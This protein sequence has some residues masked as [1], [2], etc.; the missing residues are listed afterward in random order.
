[1]R[2]FQSLAG[3]VQD[4]VV[5]I[6]TW[7]QLYSFY[8]QK[9]NRL[10]RNDQTPQYP[11]SVLCQG[12]TGIDVLTIQVYL[13]VIS[14][15]YT[16][17]PP[18][19][20]TALYNIQTVIAVRAFQRQFDLAATGRVDETTWN[21]ICLEYRDTLETENFECRFLDV[22]YPGMP[23]T[24]DQTNIFVRIALYY[25]NMIAAFD[26]LLEP[27]PITETFTREARWAIEEFQRTRGLP[28]TGAVDE[29]TWS[30]LYAQYAAAFRDLNPECFTD[31]ELPVPFSTLRVG[32]SGVYV[33]QLQIW[34]N[35]LSAY[36][37]DL[38]P[39]PVNGIYNEVTESNV[40][41]LQEFLDLPL[42]G[43][44]DRAT[45]KMIRSAYHSAIEDGA[46][47]DEAEGDTLDVTY[48]SRIVSMTD[49]VSC[50]TRVRS[51]AC[52]ENMNGT[53]A[54]ATGCCACREP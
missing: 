35:T 10:L 24:Q 8:S 38:V 44:V 43:E 48:A 23:I 15:K 30:V 40:Y 9:N 1:M 14:R 49:D 36:Y 28:I 6:Q 50:Q 7:T 34:I 11:G 19:T 17:I 3:L 54:R 47:G 51:R 53:S 2:A 26:L 32:S 13:R 46:S 41:I 4:G 29:E 31:G 5:G 20:P 21:R 25:Y 45:W 18:V 12:C 16:C 37:C 39:Q 22:S 27:I 33:E 52:A 42:T